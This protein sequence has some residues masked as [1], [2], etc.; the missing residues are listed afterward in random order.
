M[1]PTPL[2]SSLT[3]RWG[4]TA[5]VAG[6]LL[7]PTQCVH[8]REPG[9][10][11]PLCPGCEGEARRGA[12]APACPK[13]GALTGVDGGGC[14]RCRDGGL[15]HIRSVSRWTA[16]EGP[17]RRLV[18]RCKFAREWTIGEWLGEQL[19]DE[20]PV[21]EA[22]ALAGAVVP[23]PLHP[24]RMFRRGF[25]PAELIAR[26]LVRGTAVPVVSGLRRVRS[27]E[28]QSRQVSRAGRAHNVAGAFRARTGLPER[29]LLIDDVLTSGATVI[30]CARAMKKAGV[31]HIDVAV[32]AVADPRTHDGEV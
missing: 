6:E 23:V 22:V 20:P 29:V 10:G 21:A 3:R 32:I 4:L 2:I 8:C 7:F 9:R 12:V 24:W 25:N 1:R 14:Q 16:Y 31:K 26:Q 27:T 30:E 18:L 13:C 28:V 5:A 15:T 11:Y 19:A 17:V